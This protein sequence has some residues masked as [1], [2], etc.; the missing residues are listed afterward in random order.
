MSMS[1]LSSVQCDE[2][3]N[4]GEHINVLYGH[5]RK[6]HDC[7]QSTASAGL[8]P[9]VKVT[10]EDGVISCIFTCRTKEPT[11]HFALWLI[12]IDNVTD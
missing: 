8:F 11:K 2:F 3:L 7:G 1:P 4:F 12:S 6:K 5:R 9:G 10:P